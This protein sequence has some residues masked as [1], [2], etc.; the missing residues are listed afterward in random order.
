M[1]PGHGIKGPGRE[2]TDNGTRTR[3]NGQWDQNTEYRTMG[4]KHGISDNGTKTRNNGQWYQDM[5]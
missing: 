5:E 2:A 3:N 1:G 4:P